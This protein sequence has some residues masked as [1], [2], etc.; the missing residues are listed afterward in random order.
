MRVVYLAK[1]K[2]SA[3]LALDWLVAERV[4]V[5]AVVASEPDRFTR[6]EQRVDL[7]AKRHG[8][9]LSSDAELY[10]RPPEDIDAV[11]SFLFWKRIREPLLSLGRIGCLNFHPAPL[12]DMRGLGGYNVAV[13]EGMSE[14]GVSCHF[15]D[16]EFDTGDLVEVARFP[17]DPNVATAFSLDLESQERLLALF[18][19]VIARARDGEELPRTP[20]GEGRYVNR[21]E[22]ESLR[23]VRPGDDLDR[24][25][26]AFWYPPYPGAVVEVDGR[27]LTLVSE[28]LLAEAA[29]A[30]RD[31]GRVP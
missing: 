7:V 30:Y 29:E 6:E 8:L 24:K 28:Q 26:R 5:A 11:I 10:E 16:P 22:F 20:Q 27:E 21:E 19:R 15:V 1:C 3:A 18:K 23:R 14:W 9:R 13:L 12:P 31:A 4:E 25:L 2:R 17:I